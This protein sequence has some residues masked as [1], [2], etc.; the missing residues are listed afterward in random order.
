[1]LQAAGRG[2]AEHED[3]GRE[4]AGRDRPS[5]AP[6]DSRDCERAREQ[7]R[8]DQNIERADGRIRIEPRPQEEDRREDQRLRIGDARMSAIMIRIPERHRAGMQRVRKETEEGVGLVLGIPGND[9]VGHDPL[10]QR[11]Q[12]E[13]DDDGAGCRDRSDA[14]GIRDERERGAARAPI[15]PSVVSPPLYIS[16]EASL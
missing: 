13:R 9:A 14:E 11:D 3:A 1:M 10:R 5:R 2:A 15:A 7:M 12:P 8:I 6:A 4:H 16:Y